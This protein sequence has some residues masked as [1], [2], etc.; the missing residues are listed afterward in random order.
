M[1]FKTVWKKL[2][3]SLKTSPYEN[4]K[5]FTDALTRL[6]QVFSASKDE[7]QQKKY[8]ARE[9]ELLKSTYGITKRGVLIDVNY[10]NTDLKEV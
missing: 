2:V 7:E 4:K 5:I 9:A 10:D 8:K 3:A 6:G 1:T